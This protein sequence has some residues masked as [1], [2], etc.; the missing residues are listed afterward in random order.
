MILQQN[1]Q[2]A[3]CIELNKAI[4]VA[5]CSIFSLVGRL[6]KQVYK[7]EHL[8]LQGLVCITTSLSACITA[9]T[10]SVDRFSNG[11]LDIITD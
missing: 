9:C 3:K 7:S 8:R 11:N 4:L 1:V 5:R 10:L 2:I 6:F